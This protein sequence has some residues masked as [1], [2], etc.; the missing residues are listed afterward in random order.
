[1]AYNFLERKLFTLKEN[2]MAEK[3][4]ITSPS[5]GSNVLGTE[6]IEDHDKGV[7]AGTDTQLHL[8]AL[9]TENSDAEKKLHAN[10]QPE[11][12]NRR[13]D[14]EDINDDELIVDNTDGQSEFLEANETDE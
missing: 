4:N 14:I 5:M 6:T 8:A 12:I 13:K 2:I 10:D 1:M 7:S 3:E 11:A 9:S